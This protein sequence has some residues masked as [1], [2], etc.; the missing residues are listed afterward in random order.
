MQMGL[1]L[2]N[3]F[4]ILLFNYIIL[5][6]GSSPLIFFFLIKKKTKK[7]KNQKTTIWLIRLDFGMVD[8]NTNSFRAWQWGS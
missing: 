3:Y 1:D 4:S 6:K 8:S 2:Y 5:E 7:K